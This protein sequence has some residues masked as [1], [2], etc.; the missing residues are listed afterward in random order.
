MDGKDVSTT[1]Q[2]D[3][4][5]TSV[6]TSQLSVYDFGEVRR[7][8][9]IIIKVPTEKTGQEQGVCDAVATG[10]V[11]MSLRPS[12]PHP[13]FLLLDTLLIEGVGGCLKWKDSGMQMWGR[14]KAS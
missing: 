10:G 2:Y 9:C 13:G 1:F 14:R 6:L 11:K 8:H 12:R 3:A 4:I 7:V 5:H